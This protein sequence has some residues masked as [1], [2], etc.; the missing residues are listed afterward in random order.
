MPAEGLPV[1]S[2]RAEGEGRRAGLKRKAAEITRSA[3]ENFALLTT[4]ATDQIQSQG[5]GSRDSRAWTIPA[6]G[7]RGDE[8]PTGAVRSCEQRVRSATQRGSL[9]AAAAAAVGEGSLLEDSDRLLALVQLVQRLP[10]VA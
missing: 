5:R 8:H 9:A 10:R 3:G 6:A 1:A 2:E 4:R 7:V